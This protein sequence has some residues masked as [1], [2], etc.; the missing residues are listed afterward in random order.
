MNKTVFGLTAAVVLISACSVQPARGPIPHEDAPVIPSDDAEEAFLSDCIDESLFDGQALPDSTPEGTAIHWEVLA[1]DAEIHS[2]ILSKTAAAEE[3]EIISLHASAGNSSFTFPQ[4]TLNDPLVAHVIAYFSSDGAD[5]EQLKLAYTYNGTY[6][7]KVNG[8]RGILKPSIGTK[9]LRDPSLVRKPGGGFALLATQGYDTDSVYAYDT[10]DLV[11]Y[12]NERMLCLNAS[13]DGSMSGFQAWAPE[14]FY[15]P[16]LETYII[17]WSSPKDGGIFYSASKDLVETTY[18]RMLIDPG[19]ETIDL[20]VTHTPSGRAA[21]L[22]DERTPMEEYS[23][24]YRAK[25]PAWYDLTAEEVPLYERHQLEGPMILKS[26][27]KDG[28]YIYADD[29]TRSEYRVYYT[30]D[31]YSGALQ[32]AEDDDVLIPIEKPSHCHSIPVTWKELE[33]IFAV[34]PDGA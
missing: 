26:N 16:L 32:E 5:K 24:L 11:H 27:E 12:E 6:W 18:P 33:R 31:I 10:A 4:L 7:F 25:G 34:Y 29:Y 23:Q 13:P 19:F 8:D 22:K 20:T 2:N 9:R 14:A 1:G 17:I 3:Y 15:D 28:W 21:I 30:D